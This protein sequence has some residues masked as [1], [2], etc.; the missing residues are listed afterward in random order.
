M[1]RYPSCQKGEKGLTA[2]Q[3]I[4]R[5][6]GVSDQDCPMQNPYR[7]EVCR[8]NLKHYLD[9]LSGRRV[10]IMLI[11]EAPGYR[12]CALTGIPFTDEV[13]LKLSENDFALGGGGVGTREP[14]AHRSVPPPPYGKCFGNIISSR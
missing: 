13:Q 4:E 2:E 8:Y 1:T 12:G 5:L 14:A 10:D 7:N 11:G 3:L 6:A 9:Y